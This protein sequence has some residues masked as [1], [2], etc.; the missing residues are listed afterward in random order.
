M[1]DTPKSFDDSKI[2]ELAKRAYQ[3]S[4][5][6]NHEYVTYEHYLA[7]L[8]E[9]P[10][11]IEVLGD[12][13]GVDVKSISVDLKEFFD[14]GFVPQSTRPPRETGKVVQLLKQST[15]Q[16]LFS[17]RTEINSLD[18]LLALSQQDDSHAAAFLNKA[19]LRPLSLKNYLIEKHN[20]EN[21]EDTSSV[22]D[23]KPSKEMDEEQAK[24]ILAKFCVNLNEL[25]GKGKIDPLIGREAEVYKTVQITARR[26]KNNVIFVG[27]PGVGKSQLVEGLA[28][29]ISQKKTPKVLWD[30]TIY[31]LDVGSLLAGTKYRGDMEDRIKMVLKA[32]SMVK[33]SMLFIDEIHMIMGAGSGGANS[34]VDVSNLLKPALAKGEIRCIGATTYEDYRKYFEKDRALLRRFEKVDVDEPS[35]ED[36][37][38]ILMGVK[39]HYEEYHNVE[40]TEEAINLAV[41]LTHRYVTNRFLPDKA[42]DI[43]DSAGARI[44]IDDNDIS[45]I[46]AAD[47]IELEV[48]KIAKVPP[49]TVKES[50][51][52]KLSH[53]EHNFKSNVFGQQE[54]MSVLTDAVYLSRSGLRDLEKP[55]LCALFSGPT[56]TGKSASVIS[57]ADT[58]SIPLVRF[59]MSEYMEKHSVSKFIGSPPGYVGYG[60]G[61]AGSGKLINE[62]EK[63]PHCVLLLDEIEKAHPDVFNILLQVLDAGR[64]TSSNGK[65]VNFKNVY[66]I[67]TTN[68]GAAEMEKNAMGFGKIDREGDDDD[69]IKKMFTPEFRNRLDVVVK[70]KRLT[71]EV[72]LLVVDKFIKQLNKLSSEKNINIKLDNKARD[73]LSIKGYD[74]KMGARPLGRVIEQN[75]KKV[76]YSLEEFRPQ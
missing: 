33:K 20:P 13:D 47:A 1:S 67:M 70:F 55:L 27:E 66:I 40:Y 35:V 39:K 69:A 6:M 3:L 45:K 64:L 11:V 36:T 8:L 68:A 15:L 7:S 58:L 31:S 46:V 52:K 29:L 56:G 60:D 18:V 63:N 53:L 61:D 19:G 14:G 38:R 22:K 28:L 32:L 21:G 41:D 50:E 23:G 17:G 54:A 59:D 37:K 49:N 62:I 48:S 76:C 74:S 16:L 25:A 10:S 75:I 57:L 4:Y 44:R 34:S 43:I 2:I 73:W 24:K 51:A 30:S 65:T 12:M 26:K 72:M 9:D 5:D 71:P 42:I